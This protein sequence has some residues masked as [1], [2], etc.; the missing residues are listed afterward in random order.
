[1]MPSFLDL[2]TEIRL[3]IYGYLFC[4]LAIRPSRKIGW[5]RPSA[6]FSS[7]A[8]LFSNHQI[9]STLFTSSQF[10]A[11]SPLILSALVSIAKILV[12]DHTDYTALRK[13]PTLKSSALSPQSKVNIHAIQQN[14]RTIDFVDKIDDVLCQPVDAKRLLDSLP[15]LKTVRLTSPHAHHYARTI[16]DEFALAR[17]PPVGTDHFHTGLTFTDGNRMFG[18]L[19][20]RTKSTGSVLV[21]L[22]LLVWQH[23]LYGGAPYRDQWRVAKMHKLL[24]AAEKKQVAVVVSFRNIC[25]IPASGAHPPKATNALV[26]C[27]DSWMCAFRGEMSTQDWILKL[28]HRDGSDK[29]TIKQRRKWDATVSQHGCGQLRKV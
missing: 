12:V 14:L 5:N 17:T 9:L 2:P 28:W 3:K 24:E 20:A 26:G 16:D 21:D 1:M 29:Y 13:L 22:S 4:G 11:D 25:F 23:F 19:T 15:S 8:L 6:D 7:P 27:K 10:K 18:S